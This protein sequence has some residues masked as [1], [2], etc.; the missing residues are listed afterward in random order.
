MLSNSTVTI[1]G[2]TGFL[3]RSIVREMAKQGKTIKIPSREPPKALPLKVG[4]QA[5]QITPIRCS[6][7]NEADVCEAIIGSDIV[8]NLVGQTKESK[9]CSFESIHVE[10]AARIARISKEAG[11]KKLLHFSA[12]GSDAKSRSNYLRS[13]ASGELAVRTFFPDAIIFRPSIVFGHD[14]T[15]FNRIM[16]RARLS[17]IIFVPGGSSLKLCP[18]YVGD[19]AAAAS[20]AL[21]E[22]NSAGY[23]YNITCNNSYSM[24]ALTE[25]MLL[26]TNLCRYIVNMPLPFAKMLAA[27]LDVLNLPHIEQSKLE[28][29]EA[30]GEPHPQNGTKTISDLKVIPTPIENI[31]RL[32]A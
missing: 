20:T 12:L 17:P 10:A 1:F 30:L 21:S 9:E 27:S 32:Y 31:F 6:I 18:I 14:D 7:R 8:I 4:S 23:T 2:G 3:G 25:L 19:I 28:T 15:F 11:V 16:S 13:K 24:R 22:N 26:E 29:L 5:G